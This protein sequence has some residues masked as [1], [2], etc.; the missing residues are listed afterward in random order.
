M[1][2]VAEQMKSGSIARRAARV[3]CRLNNCWATLDNFTPE[4]L[5]VA[6]VFTNT[7]EATFNEHDKDSQNKQAHA[8]LRR[9]FRQEEKVCNEAAQK[10]A[11]A[12]V[13]YTCELWSFRE[14]DSALEGLWMYEMRELLEEQIAIIV[15]GYGFED[16]AFKKTGCGYCSVCGHEFGGRQ[17]DHLTVHLKKAISVVSERG[18]PAAA[19]LPKITVKRVPPVLDKDQSTNPLVGVHVAKVEQKAVRRVRRGKVTSTINKLSAMTTPE[20]NAE[21]VGKVIEHTVECVA[22]KKSGKGTKKS[23]GCFAGV[24]KSVDLHTPL[25]SKQATKAKA[26]QN[27]KGKAKRRAAVAPAETLYLPSAWV[28]WEAKKLYPPSRI[29]L[30][31]SLYH[32]RVH[33]GWLIL[34]DAE[35]TPE[36]HGRAAKSIYDQFEDQLVKSEMLL[37]PKEL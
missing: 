32:Q 35:K 25:P 26:R 6:I 13:F 22:A 28:Q 9:R 31:L 33:D 8:M 14:V 11:D 18:K 16:L 15:V 27:A 24:I 19:H 3:N 5:E 29:F 7:L 34:G 4:E 12:L 17:V 30:N 2:Y 36:T 1:K 21:L 37:V 23:L 20:V 10:Y